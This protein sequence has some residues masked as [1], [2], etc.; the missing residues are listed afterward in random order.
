MTQ[1]TLGFVDDNDNG[2]SQ[3][4]GEGLIAER[5]QQS[6]QKWEKTLHDTGGYLS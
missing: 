6:A 4:K 2:V 1:A 5:L 3:E